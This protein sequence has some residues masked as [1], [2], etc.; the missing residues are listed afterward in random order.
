LATLSW[1]GTE[2]TL[3]AQALTV[4]AQT[5]PAD[6]NGELIWDAFFPMV[7]VRSTKIRN[8]ITQQ[9]IRYTADRREYNARGR[10]IPFDTSGVEMIRITPIES[11]FKIEEEE[12]Q[13]LEEQ[14]TDN[15][16]LFRDIIRAA[17]PERVDVITRTDWRRVEI[18]VFRSW[19]TGQIT[20]RNPQLGHVAQTFSYGIASGHYLTA[21][22]QWTDAS[23]NAFDE[24]LKW[25]DAAEKVVGLVQGAVMRRGVYSVLQADASAALSLA[26]FPLIRLTQRQFEERV[27][28][29]RGRSFEFY[30]VENTVK[31]FSDA[32]MTVAEVNLWPAATIAAVPVSGSPGFVAKAPVGRAYELARVSPEAKID[33]NGVSVYIETAGNGRELT[34]EAQLNAMPILNEEKLYVTSN[35][36]P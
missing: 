24:F 31:E 3:T 13:E 23:L 28:E 7:P 8:I 14:T 1:V 26:G 33:R 9:E 2:D 32:G 17:I 29:E 27:S 25:L 6:N 4:R 12:M 21:A 34:C 35:I 20:V 10:L 19:S 36:H 5:L 22:T 18:D 11:Y 30:V 15:E 16:A